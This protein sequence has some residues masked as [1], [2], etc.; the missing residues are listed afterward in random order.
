MKKAGA[1]AAVLVAFIYVMLLFSSGCPVMAVSVSI[2][3]DLAVYPVWG[4]GGTVKVT[5][6]NFAP[7]FTYYLWLQKPKQ[8][9][10]N[11]IAVH[12][13]PVKG[14]AQPPIL[15]TI[16]AN[17]PPGTYTLTVSNSSS[18][19]TG[20][21]TVH[22]GV[23]GTDS[24]A[25]ERTRTVTVA[26][27]GFAPDSSISM[28]VAAGNR[29][30]PNFPLNIT[31]DRNGDY[32]YTFKLTPSTTTG[33]VKAT[34]SGLSF[35]KHETTWANST[36]NIQLAPITVRPLNT[37]TPLVERT[38]TVSISYELSYPD[39]SPVATAN[40]SVAI[41]SGNRT[42]ASVSLISVNATTGEY[43]ASWTPAPSASTTAYHFML[44]PANL[45]DSY[46][47]T[48]QSSSVSS[49]DFNVIAANMAPAIRTD[50]TRERT[51][52]ASVIIS[53]VYH[54]GAS[55]ANVTKATVSVTQ[56]DGRPIQ[57]PTSIAGPLAAANFKI[58]VNAT[59]GSW[60]VAFSVQDAWGNSASGKFTVQVLP[61][62]PV[63]QLDTPSTV[64]RTT[65]L[66][67]TTK[68]SY[69]DGTAWNKTIT[70]TISH[71]NQTWTPKLNFNSTTTE[72]SGSIYLVQNATL[73]PYN[74]TLGAADSYGNSGAINSTTLAIPA[75]FRFFLRSNNSTVRSFSNID[76]PVTVTYPNGT[77]LPNVLGNVT[78]GNVTASYK[79]ST[80]Y[81]FTLPLAYNETNATWH[82]YFSTPESGNLTFSFTAMDP[83]G[84]TGMAADAYNLKVNSSGMILQ[85]LIIAGAV[86]AMVPSGVLIWAFATISTRRRKHKP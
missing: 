22:F 13:T 20:V 9:I 48:G 85:T 14:V 70:M 41:L 57:I 84:N 18:T 44:S 56:P 33:P 62:S 66:N 79:N 50:A 28:G 72:W 43:A 80:G 77:S 17:D 19:D 26:G 42:V 54:D 31:A 76:L 30:F 61:A 15:L 83:F 55:I 2:S 81:I 67:V 53:A 73:G 71:G 39:G 65:F 58:P 27:G 36:F 32:E 38:A 51:Q 34:V 49:K 6:Q 74:V 3:T 86:G 63:F 21:A 59:L 11:P 29:T 8:L 52:N 45:V 7:N 5:V 25:Y 37:P 4:V 16:A 10:P 12:F 40:S 75:Q 68:I 60:S 24:Q 78:F 1:V 82:M 46:G 47:N 23:S 35:D 69:P 64:Q